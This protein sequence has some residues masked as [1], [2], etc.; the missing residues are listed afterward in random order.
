MNIPCDHWGCL[1]WEEYYGQGAFEDIVEKKPGLVKEGIF[2][3]P[4]SMLS[5]LWRDGILYEVNSKLG[6]LLDAYEEEDISVENLKKM[7]P[8]LHQFK[9]NISKKLDPSSILT[10]IE[11]ESIPSVNKYV[12]TIPARE[13]LDLLNQFIEYLQDAVQ[14][15]KAVTFSL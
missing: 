15:N 13:Y 12:A 11:A 3:L 8:F 9:E 1:Y 5:L 4:P 14:K 10:H 7:I 6:T 2:Y